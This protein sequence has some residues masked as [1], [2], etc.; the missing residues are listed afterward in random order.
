MCHLANI[1]WRTGHTLNFDPKTH[2]IVEDRKASALWKREY[3]R[4]WEPAI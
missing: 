4:G 2:K 3:R 1:A